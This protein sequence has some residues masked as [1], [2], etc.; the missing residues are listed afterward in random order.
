[1]DAIMEESTEG[2]TDSGE[3]SKNSPKNIPE[4]IVENGEKEKE[5][6]SKGDNGER[7]VEKDSSNRVDVVESA[8]DDN[9]IEKE[10]NK[11]AQNDVEDV[12]TTRTSQRVSGQGMPRRTKENNKTGETEVEEQNTSKRVSGQGIQRQKENKTP[13]SRKFHNIRAI[14]TPQANKAD[15]ASNV[16]FTEGSLDVSGISG[17]TVLS[18]IT[19]LSPPTIRDTSASRRSSRNKDKDDTAATDA[20][21]FKFKKGNKDNKF[22]KLVVNGED[23]KTNRKRKSDENDHSRGKEALKPPEK[24][25]S[26][27]SALLA[28]VPERNTRKN[29]K[30]GK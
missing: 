1:M 14:S 11:N 26:F 24:R 10:N 30:K 27:G 4:I 8:T 16:T 25:P 9:E 13:R 2:P 20:V 19:V 17:Y 6:N 21:S 15:L 7:P 23:G 28:A 18:G 12:N 3:S 29:N 5:N 22:E